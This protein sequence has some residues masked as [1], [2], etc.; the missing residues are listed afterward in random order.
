[1]DTFEET[2]FD[3]TDLALWGIGKQSGIDVLLWRRHQK[4]RRISYLKGN[5]S[6]SIDNPSNLHIGNVY[7]PPFTFPGV[8]CLKGGILICLMCTW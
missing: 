7:M 8:H 2:P 6:P 4:S 3:E 1:M 5:P